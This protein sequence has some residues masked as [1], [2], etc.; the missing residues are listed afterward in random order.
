ML[1]KRRGFIQSI[2]GLFAVSFMGAK[3]LDLVAEELPKAPSPKQHSVFPSIR[4]VGDERERENY[5]PH[6]VGD[7]YVNSK[8]GNVFVYTGS[9]WVKI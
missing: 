9:K 7:L 3:S 4:F 1:M 6:Y 5:G 2:G 8:N